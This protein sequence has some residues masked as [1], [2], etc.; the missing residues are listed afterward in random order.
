LLPTEEI[1]DT[2]ATIIAADITRTTEAV[3]TGIIAI[4]AI[5]IAGMDIAAAVHTWALDRATIPVT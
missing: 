1:M 5:V 3:I 2:T 4:T